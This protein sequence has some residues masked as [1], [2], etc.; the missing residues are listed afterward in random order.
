MSRASSKPASKGGAQPCD[1]VVTAIPDGLLA[2]AG[3]LSPQLF[4]ETVQ[5]SPMAISITDEQANILYVNPAFESLTGY[6]GATILGKNESILSHKQTP[7]EVY[8]ELWATIKAKRTW[9]GTLVNRRHCGSAYLAELSITPV[10]NDKGAIVNFLGIHRDVTE[11]HALE[12]QVRHQKELMESV[13]DAAPVVVALVDADRRV[14]LDNQEYKKL[15]G[16]L[17]GREPAGLFLDA[18]RQDGIELDAI[19]RKGEGFSAMEVRLDIGGHAEPRW[20][21]VSGTWVDEL[22]SAADTYFSG[23]PRGR[24]CLLLLASE[25]TKLKRQMEQLRMQHLRANLAEQQRVQ[26]MREALSG[27]I[28][29]MQTPVNVMQAAVGMLDRG[30]DLA[31]TREVLEQVLDSGRQAVETLSGAL[32]AELAEGATSVNLNAL[33]RDVMTLMTEDF[34][35]RGAIIEWHPQTVLH[36]II[37]RPNQ[38]R[39]MFMRLVENALLAVDEPGRDHRVVRITTRNTDEGVEVLMHDS[40]PGIPEDLRL[41][42]FE[43]F[44]TGWEHARGRAGMGLAMVQEAVNQHGGVI[45]INPAVREGCQVRLVFPLPAAGNDRGGDWE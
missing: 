31:N 42:V 22:D 2:A 7:L 43:P 27:A 16:D 15:L 29:Q 20:F 13:L 41:K 37:G 8:R 19:C 14:V 44:F 45:D 34:L 21:S 18:L 23:S 5:Q 25:I 11:L 28:F 36:S 10:V 1:P 26:G 12:R 39:G 40:G 38:L 3:Q 32:P 35:S 6:T 9:R 4:Y 33:L 17:R 24:C 30:T